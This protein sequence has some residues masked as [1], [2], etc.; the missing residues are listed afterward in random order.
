MAEWVAHRGW[1]TRYPE[2]TLASVTAAL[3][4]G[5]RWVEVDVQLT[6]D[7]VPVLLHDAT[8]NR[9]TGLP[10]I[11]F[12]YSAEELQALE[13]CDIPRLNEVLN[14]LRQ[15]PEA[16]LLVEVKDESVE[17]FGLE[18]TVTRV[19][20]TIGRDGAQCVLIAFNEQVLIHA[21]QQCAA[22]VGWI[23]DRCDAE[24]HCTAESLQP[25]FLICN[26]QKLA[27]QPPWPG[28]WQWMLYEINDCRTASAFAAQGVAYIETADIGAMLEACPDPERLP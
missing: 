18:H 8:L 14:A 1:K 20:E 23:L 25:E 7:G 12:D 28:T 5:G 3:H 11:V 15:Y 24:A 16:T 13:R 19:I 27:G 26:Y 6:R 21:R 22:P 17:R 4:A 10:G 9:T 2:N